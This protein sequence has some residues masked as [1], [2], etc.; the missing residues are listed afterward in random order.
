MY[1]YSVRKEFYNQIVSFPNSK[2]TV[3]LSKDTPQE[4]LEK[5]YIKDHPAI[6]RRKVKVNE[7]SDNGTGSI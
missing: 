2:L 5:L 1:K 7:E 4:Y 6:I 3:E